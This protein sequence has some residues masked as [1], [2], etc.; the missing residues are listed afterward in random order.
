MIEG[1]NVFLSGAEHGLECAAGWSVRVLIGKMKSTLRETQQQVRTRLCSSD[2]STHSSPSPW[3]SPATW[4]I[5]EVM[6]FPMSQK[7]GGISGRDKGGGETTIPY[8]VYPSPICFV[9]S[10]YTLL[11][12][13]FSSPQASWSPYSTPRRSRVIL[14]RR[15]RI[16]MVTL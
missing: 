8:Q 16:S 3:S 13:P 15:T 12:I 10:L 6:A 2:S 4:P 7:D 14:S 5:R 9:M 11:A 1:Q